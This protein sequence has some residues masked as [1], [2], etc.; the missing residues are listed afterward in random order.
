MCIR[1]SAN[2]IKIVGWCWRIGIDLEERWRWMIMIDMLHHHR[3]RCRLL[4]FAFARLGLI[5]CRYTKIWSAF[6]PLEKDREKNREA[7][8][9]DAMPSWRS[10]PS[11]S[12]SPSLRFSPFHSFIDDVLWSLGD[13]LFCSIECWR[14]AERERERE[15]EDDFAQLNSTEFYSKMQLICINSIRHSLI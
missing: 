5:P 9:A 13:F 14:C 1:D 4:F 15:D 3:C 10:S 6:C 12:S 11:P 7:E 8:P 2:L